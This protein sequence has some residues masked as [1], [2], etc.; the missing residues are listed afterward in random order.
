MQSILNELVLGIISRAE[1]IG[2]QISHDVEPTVPDL[3]IDRPLLL[4]ALENMADNAL[5]WMPNGGTLDI[6]VAMDTENRSI[7]ITV[8][9]DGPGVPDENKERIFEPFFTTKENGTG[10]GLAIARGVI[11]GHE[12]EVEVHDRPG[13]GAIFV[14]HV[15][16][17]RSL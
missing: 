2:V 4:A 12:G 17:I 1:T 10:L 9:D 6:Q 11:Q 15:P 7:R 14:V 5:D 3:E 16:L 13:G 8:M